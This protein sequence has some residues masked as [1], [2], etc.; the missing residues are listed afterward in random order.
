MLFLFIRPVYDAFDEEAI[1]PVEEA[2]VNTCKRADSQYT[3]TAQKSEKD[4]SD[5]DSNSG[6]NA[7]EIDESMLGNIDFEC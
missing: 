3:Y 2:L 1:K 6:D 4:D 7:I 5:D